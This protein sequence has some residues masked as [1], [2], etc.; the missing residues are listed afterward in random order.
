MI[1]MIILRVTHTQY[2]QGCCV[3]RMGGA[4]SIAKIDY[5]GLSEHLS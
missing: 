2:E 1:I 4:D 5:I 3:F